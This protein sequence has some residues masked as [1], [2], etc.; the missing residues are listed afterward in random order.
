MIAKEHHTVAC[1][2]TEDPVIFMMV[3]DI[4]QPS[5]KYKLSHLWM[6]DVY[7]CHH[8]SLSI[9]LL[10]AVELLAAAPSPPQG[11]VYLGLKQQHEMIVVAHIMHNIFLNIHIF[12][13]S[14][15]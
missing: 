5:R 1:R 9:V 7:L 2:G 6:I 8:S 15:F 11:N 3:N 10:E 4:L 13:S 14:L 12:L